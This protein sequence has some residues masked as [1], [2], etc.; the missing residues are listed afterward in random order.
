MKKYKDSVQNVHICN[1]NM[2]IKTGFTCTYLH[3]STLEEKCS[4]C[5]NLTVP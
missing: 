1:N 4:K 3:H 2:R 5:G